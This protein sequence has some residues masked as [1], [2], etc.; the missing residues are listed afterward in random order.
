MPIPTPNGHMHML[1]Q[2]MASPKHGTF[3]RPARLYLGL[4]KDVTA[5]ELLL[6]V[7]KRDIENKLRLMHRVAVKQHQTV[8]VP[9]GLL[10]AIG[11]GIMVAEV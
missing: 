5:E 7:E 11:E 9:P 8:Y 6:M 1:E 10:H 2:L 4:Q 3:Y